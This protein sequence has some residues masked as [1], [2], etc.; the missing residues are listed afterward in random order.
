MICFFIDLLD[1]H[2]AIQH[3][4]HPSIGM[5]PSPWCHRREDVVSTKYLTY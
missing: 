5:A 2:R 3:D 4:L 1:L